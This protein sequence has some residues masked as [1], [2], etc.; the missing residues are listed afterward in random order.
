MWPRRRTDAGELPLVTP[1]IRAAAAD[2]GGHLWI[3][4]VEPFT[5][6][7]DADG[8]KIRTVQ[9]RAAGIRSPN[10]LFFDADGRLLDHAGDVRVSSVASAFRRTAVRPAE[11]GRYDRMRTSNDTVRFRMSP[12]T[13][14][15]MSW[16]NRFVTFTRP[17]TLPFIHFAPTLPFTIVY[18]SV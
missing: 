2:A 13:C 6:V 14:C 10:H 1:T 9:F 15:W 5:Y 8:D 4:F 11:A 3:S 7:F 12:N 17:V 18:A 16:L